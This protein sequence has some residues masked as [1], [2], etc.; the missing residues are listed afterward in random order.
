MPLF[1][2]NYGGIASLFKTKKPQQMVV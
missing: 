2:A 1:E